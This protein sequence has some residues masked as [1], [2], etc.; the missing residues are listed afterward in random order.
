[1]QAIPTPS[2]CCTPCTTPSS[3]AVPGPQG[4]AGANGTN[5]TNGINAFATVAG[6]F[7]MPAEGA[8]AI[9]DVNGSTW[10][11]VGQILWVRN[12]GWLQVT[13]LP[14]STSVT[15]LN[16]KNTVTG[17]YLPNV[18]PG[19]LVAVGNAVIPSGIQGPAGTLGG[20]GGGDLE[21]TF[22]NP[23]LKIT[24][25][26]GDLVVN[27]QSAIAPRNTRLGAGAN[28]T[29]L[30]GRSTAPTGLEWAA[31]DMSGVSSVLSGVLPKSRG[32]LNSGA[33]LNNNR[34]MV[35]SGDAVVETAAL[36]N[37]QLLIGS[38]GAAPVAAVLSA[39]AGIAIATGAGTCTI[40]STVAASGNSGLK[41]I[42]A[43]SGVVTTAHGLAGTPSY[44]RTVLVCQVAEAGYTGNE[45]VSYDHTDD[46]VG[47]VT[48]Y[49]D[50]VN[51][52]VGIDATTT[53]RVANK[54]TGVT[55]AITRA[56]WKFKTYWAAF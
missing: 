44:V 19:T 23:T 55:T 22:P 41:A 10:M 50:S 42:P 39:G 11:A 17:V 29:M 27:N 56:K 31:V 13:A 25:T 43:A 45:E 15:L 12:A 8:T 18:A 30:H 24:T 52:V 2:D 14:S 38:T 16:L 33:A 28:G 1:M 6:Q 47:V 26:K 46:G 4:P 20:A 36:L 21:G 49:A 40:S 34:I 32:G 5:G 51:V 35:S 37:G 48:T 3:V 9:V 7:S 53:M 54:T